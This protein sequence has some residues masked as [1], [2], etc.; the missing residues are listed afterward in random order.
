MELL[1]ASIAQ[2]AQFALAA[3]Y[4]IPFVWTAWILCAFGFG[5]RLPQFVTALGFTAVY[6]MTKCCS[7]TGHGLHLA[8]YALITLAL[9]TRPGRYSLDGL[10]A[11]YWPRYPLRPRPHVDASGFA[12]TVILGLAIYT[13]FAGG[14][15]KLYVAG[16][17]WLDGET[18]QIHVEEMNHPKGK[19]GEWVLGLV[20]ENRWIAAILSTWTIL[21]EVGSIVA[22]FFPRTR[23]VLI[24]NAWLFHLGIYLIMLPKYFPQMV[25]YLLIFHWRPVIDRISQKDHRTKSLSGATLQQLQPSFI[26]KAKNVLFVFA[27]VASLIL[28]LC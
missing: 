1:P 22:L 2:P 24:V 17:H 13:L 4:L 20:L 27:L 6:S 23:N 26:H 10:I 19:I 5:G 16:F 14:L 12:R 9:F 11:T 15:T 28:G 3:N 18:L 7:G 21:L 8:M 25:V